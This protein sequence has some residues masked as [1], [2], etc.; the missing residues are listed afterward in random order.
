LT[1][2]KRNLLCDIALD[3]RFGI[4]WTRSISQMGDDM[5]REYAILAINDH[6]GK[7]VITDEQKHA[8]V[9]PS[10]S[11]DALMKVR[12]SIEKLRANK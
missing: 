9:D 10:R 1:L 12:A 11:A 2:E 8:L 3:K 5:D 4:F 6:A 7:T